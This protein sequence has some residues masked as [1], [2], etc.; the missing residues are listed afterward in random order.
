MTENNVLDLV[1]STQAAQITEINDEEKLGNSDHSGLSFRFGTKVK[2]QIKSSQLVPNFSKANF[3][4]IKQS[5]VEIDWVETYRDVSVEEAWVHFSRTLGD[6][7]KRHIPLIKRR[8]YDNPVW[9][10]KNV[11]QA[12]KR[13]RKAWVRY[14]SGCDDFDSYKREEKETKKKILCN[15]LMMK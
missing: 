4:Q 11:L 7:V 3:Q 14:H 15:Y 10:N 12:V 6:L 5:L 8:S 1:L 9:A 2:S 13:K